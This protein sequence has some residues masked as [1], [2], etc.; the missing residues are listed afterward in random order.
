LPFGSAATTTITVKQQA[1][2][3]TVS[4][5]KK[6]I[7]SKPQWIYVPNKD[8][9]G[10]DSFIL[11]ANYFS[12]KLDLYVDLQ[13]TG[14]NDAPISSGGESSAQEDSVLDGQLAA[15]DIEGDPLTY[16]VVAQPF[17][18]QLVLRVDGSYT[19]TPDSNF[20]GTD[21]FTFKTND[22]AADS[23]AAIVTLTVASVNDVPVAGSGTPSCDEDTAIEGTVQATDADGDPLT[24][25][26]VAVPSHGVLQL[27]VDGSYTYTPAADFHGT[28]SF[29]FKTNDGAADSNAAIVTLT[30]ASVNDV[31]VAGSGGASGGEDTEIIGAVQAT[32]A[33]GDSLIFAVV[34]GPSHGTLVLKADGSYT[35]K[36]DANFH[37]VD[38]FTFKAKDA[39]ADSEPA[40]VTLVIASVNDAPTSQGATLY[41][42]SGS[43]L[44][45]QLP[46]AS[47]VDGD[48]VTY[49]KATLPSR[50]ELTLGVDGSFAYTP[51][52]GVNEP[53]TFRF[54]VSDGNGGTS[55]YLVSL[56]PESWLGI[57]RI[58]NAWFNGTFGS[59]TMTALAS[60]VEQFFLGDPVLFAAEVYKQYGSPFAPS[61]LA[62]S[63]ANNLGLTGEANLALTLRL[64]DKLEA[65]GGNAPTLAD[66]YDRGRA[67]LAET[68]WFT[69]QVD[70]PLYGEAAS[71]F[72]AEI[73]AALKY[74]NI[75]GTLNTSTSEDGS[76]VALPQEPTGNSRVSGSRVGDGASAR[77]DDGGSGW[78]LPTDFAAIE[79]DV[80]GV[81]MPRI[82]E[83]N[84]L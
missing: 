20:Y 28:D 5:Q 60:G 47:D 80:V 42:R 38:S 82:V 37:G 63:I 49:G 70:D 79:V 84:S 22:G 27:R 34:A 75:A 18:G 73:D 81:V 29:T 39:V 76:P 2:H 58:A 12:Q 25:A 19:Y 77:S 67:L 24:F 13:I 51:V 48:S 61:D 64:R 7:L 46:V 50:G 30:V 74:A 8:Y 1:S 16:S 54:S 68:V 10:S 23:N 21:S 66:L 4:I 44:Q 55:S 40:T 83:I 56:F 26:V 35:F 17:H 78:P 11:S 52:A 62:Q 15:S 31:P 9:F 43:T 57:A 69:T 71:R 36:P 14:V 3:G 32:D 45:G 33:D 59:A 65:I 72:N 41:T 53:D 6:D